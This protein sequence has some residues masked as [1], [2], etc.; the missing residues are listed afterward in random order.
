MPQGSVLG[1]LLYDI[2]INEI[3]CFANHTNICNYADDTTV[4]AYHSDLGIVIRQLQDDCSV[5]VKWFSNNLLKLNNKKCHLMVFG[6]KNT[7]EAIKIGNSDIKGSDCEKLLGI[8]F[9]KNLNFKKHIE[10]LR[11]KAN[12]KIHALARL[13]N[14]IDPVKSE[15]L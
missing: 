5:I 15:I 4:F 8:A 6:N 10:D 3:F 12:Q 14:Y 1:P 13:S 2:F 9:D 7:E 11:R